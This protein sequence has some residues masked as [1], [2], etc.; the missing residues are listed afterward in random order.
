[1]VLAQNESSQEMLQTLVD[2]DLS[3]IEQYWNSVVIPALVNIGV[4]SG[5]VIFAYDK[6]ENLQE[7]WERAKDANSFKNMKLD[8]NWVKEK[9]G[10]EVI[11]TQESNP[12]KLSLDFFD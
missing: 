10:I 6:S 1:M 5:E 12:Q 3:L 11:E 8:P 4:I 2:S 7:L 9:F